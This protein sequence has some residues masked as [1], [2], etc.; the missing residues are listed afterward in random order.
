M[1]EAG[2][3]IRGNILKEQILTIKCLGSYIIY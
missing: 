1:Q 2:L 3:G